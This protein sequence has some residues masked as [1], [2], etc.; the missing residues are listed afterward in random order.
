MIRIQVKDE[1]AKALLERVRRGL[2]SRGMTRVLAQIGADL[3]NFSRIAFQSKRDPVTGAAWEPPAPRTLK[4]RGFR[5][6]LLRTGQL[7][8]SIT[9]EVQ[10]GEGGGNAAL[11]IQGP[12]EI[13]RRGMVHLF[14][15]RKQR[16]KG[17]GRNIR[18]LPAR[19]WTGY[20]MGAISRWNELILEETG[21][22]D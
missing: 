18:R 3:L 19:V 12:G 14:G 5:D 10:V 9:G 21:T 11:V 20:P 1:E 16:K 8:S 6:L 7:V 4:D 2:S 15:A 17:P 22:N 13:V